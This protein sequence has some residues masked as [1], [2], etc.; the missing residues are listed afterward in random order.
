M[1]LLHALDHLIAR[2]AAREFAGLR[3][4]RALARQL[5]DAAGENVVV[6]Q[7]RHDLL[8]GQALRNRDSVLH[9]LALDDG[10]DD[11]AQG[12]A[13]FWN[14]YSPGFRSELAFSANTVAMKTHGLT[15]VTPSRFRVSAMSRL[16]ARAG[17]LTI[18][19][20]FKG[21]CGLQHLPAVIIGGAG[22]EHRDQQGW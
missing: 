14:E 22:A 16:P 10:G 15:S 12:L 8:G 18:L 11:V 17:M 2:R 19:S 1:G 9:H 20:S 3:Q 6:G 5:A 4:Q 21:S 13:C 7:A